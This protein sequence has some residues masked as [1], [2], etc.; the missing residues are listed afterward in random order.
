MRLLWIPLVPAS[1]YPIPAVPWHASVFPPLHVSVP[2]S[3]NAGNNHMQSSVH[4][5]SNNTVIAISFTLIS[6]ISFKF[7]FLYLFTIKCIL[8]IF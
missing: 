8:L 3:N 5:V 7:H 6:F 4:Y 1:L 2:L